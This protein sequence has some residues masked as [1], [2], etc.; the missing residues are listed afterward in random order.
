MSKMNILIKA[1]PILLL[2]FSCNS[3]KGKKKSVESIKADITMLELIKI[4]MEDSDYHENIES[5]ITD[6]EI[7]KSENE[8]GIN[9]PNSYKLF[10]KKFGNGA[11]SLYHIDQTINGVNMEY[12]A[13]HWFGKYRKYLGEEIN[14]D[15][16]GVFKR[17]SLLCLMT[18]NSNGGAWVW[19]TSETSK[20]GEWPLA[21]YNIDDGKLYYKVSNFK[22]LIRIATKC[23]YEVIRELDKEDK[24]TLG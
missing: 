1:L 7:E 11:E 6:S 13:I 9:L 24:L 2:L 16:F 15:G 23:K 8:M 4:L 18:E 20:D 12:G 14:S 19:L 3:P 21:Y 5:K 22:E 10:L 17:D